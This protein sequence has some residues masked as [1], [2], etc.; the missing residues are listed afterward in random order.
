ML[1]LKKDLRNIWIVFALAAVALQAQSDESTQLE[2]VTNTSVS[3][4]GTY[5]PRAPQW[6]SV[7]WTYE[8]NLVEK[9]TGNLIYSMRNRIRIKSA[10]K[11][12]AKENYQH[13]KFIETKYT[14]GDTYTHK[15]TITIRRKIDPTNTDRPWMSKSHFSEKILYE[16][17][18]SEFPG[19]K[20]F[21]GRKFD[22]FSGRTNILSE[23]KNFRP[24]VLS[25]HTTTNIINETEKR[26]LGN[27]IAMYEDTHRPD[28]TKA[29]YAVIT[30][31]TKQAKYPQRLNYVVHS[32]TL[33]I[34]QLKSGNVNVLST[35]RGDGIFL[36]ETKLHVLSDWDM[37]KK[38]CFNLPFPS[39]EKQ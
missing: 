14:C 1:S 20:L 2:I 36:Q 24:N 15:G 31:E 17:P 27:Q 38:G 39:S 19:V 11:L 37:V 5:F 35:I 34:E 13:E 4:K 10:D 22:D 33:R 25:T 32:D 9:A 6:K 28:L 3:A 26:Y 18:L 8:T 21:V 30:T 29:K 16:G 12:L 23:S 7:L